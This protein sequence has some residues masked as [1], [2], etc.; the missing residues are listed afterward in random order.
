MLTPPTAT[1]IPTDADRDGIADDAD[2]HPSD[3]DNDG[4]NSTYDL[5]DDADGETDTGKTDADGDGYAGDT[6]FT[7]EQI[8]ADADADADGIPDVA[9]S[10]DATTETDDDQDGVLDTFDPDNE[11]FDA[12]ANGGPRL[13]NNFGDGYADNDREVDFHQP[14]PSEPS[15]QVRL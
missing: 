5:D 15:K 7:P 9:D 13:A 10:Y 11:G 2:S 4:V 6:D 14:P 1:P 8:A 3:Q 12:I